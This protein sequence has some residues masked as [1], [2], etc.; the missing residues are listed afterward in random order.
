MTGGAVPGQASV[1]VSAAPAP[2]LQTAMA[3]A[4]LRVGDGNAGLGLS[5]STSASRRLDPSEAF[6][7]LDSNAL[8]L[9]VDPPGMAPEEVAAHSPDVLAALTGLIVLS[10]ALTD[11]LVEVQTIGRV[12]G[13]VRPARRPTRID[14]ALTQP[15]ARALLEQ[16]D[17]LT[18]PDSP[19]PRAGGLRNGSFVAG[20]DSLTLILTAA[21]YLRVDLDLKLGDGA[22]TASL[23]LILPISDVPPPAAGDD[24]DPQARWKAA[25]RAQALASP[26]L[27]QAVL[28]PMRLP[29]KRLLSLRVGD[30]IDLPPHAL[31]DIALHGGASGITMRGRKRIPRGTA[32][33]ARLGQL[34]GMR[35][36]KISG[37]P[38]EARDGAAGAGGGDDFG[39]RMD[40]RPPT[41][42]SRAPL[43]DTR[44]AAEALPDL[45]E[46]PDL[47][48]MPDLPELPGYP[49]GP[50]V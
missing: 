32:M 12:D 3:T 9:I 41:S 8:C 20:P 49:G 45:P 28:P 44:S 13:P 38:G 15:F 48:D 5:T 24:I 50:G 47:P 11:S 43:P 16:I 7:G 17:R 30:V 40:A 2:G 23:A 14:A 1:S 34:N 10:P 26:V 35:A 22:R 39:M 25:M 37:L 19:D 4:A 42:L 46:F 31:A 29:L 18:P 33:A 36:V 21:R 6:T 27:L